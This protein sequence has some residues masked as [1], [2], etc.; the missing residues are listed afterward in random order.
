ML[1][2]VMETVT[3]VGFSKGFQYPLGY[4]DKDDSC[5]LLKIILNGRWVFCFSSCPTE[6]IVEDGTVAV[7]QEN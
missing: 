1:N 4:V 6:I 2:D 7:M 5:T 3:S